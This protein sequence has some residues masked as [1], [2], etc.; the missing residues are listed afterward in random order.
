MLPIRTSPWLIPTPIPSVIR[1]SVFHW[2]FSFS[3]GGAFRARVGAGFGVFGHTLALHVPP[4]RHNGVAD[5]FIERTSIFE[6]HLDHMAQGF[7]QM[8]NQLLRIGLLAQSRETNEVGKQN[9]DGFARSA[10]A[11]VVTAGV[12]ENFFD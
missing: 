4:N 10:H 12:F 1:P 6:N 9:R 2:S 8:S 11:G 7:V 3:V 5:E